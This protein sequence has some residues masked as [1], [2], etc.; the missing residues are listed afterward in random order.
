MVVKGRPGERAK[1]KA[2][3]PGSLFRVVADG[4]GEVRGHP[5]TLD[6]RRRRSVIRDAEVEK[7]KRLLS[8]SPNPL[9]E[10]PSAPARQEG[11]IKRTRRSP[12]CPEA[13]K[14][15]GAQSTSILQPHHEATLH[16]PRRHRRG[17]SADPRCK[18]KSPAPPPS[19]HA[20]TSPS[21]SS[22]ATAQSSVSMCHSRA[23]YGRSEKPVSTD[24][25]SEGGYRW[26]GCR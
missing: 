21:S 25:G 7:N 20:W 10:T 12:I 11:S 13:R 5:V 4:R 3:A 17:R 18:V 24:E 23:P 16:H 15:V 22:T 2:P 19:K 14:A 6:K 8:P 9:A 1:R 26:E